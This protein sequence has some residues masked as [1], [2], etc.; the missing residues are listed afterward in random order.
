MPYIF[1]VFIR[2]HIY[3]EFINYRFGLTVKFPEI[4]NSWP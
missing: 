4:I 3:C 1:Q 2:E